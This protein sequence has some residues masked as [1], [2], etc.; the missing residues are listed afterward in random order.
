V[1]IFQLFAFTKKWNWIKILLINYKLSDFL[2][3][4]F[5]LIKTFKNISLER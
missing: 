3:Y 4:I 5:T 2:I 1:V